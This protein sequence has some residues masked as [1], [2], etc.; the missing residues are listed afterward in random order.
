LLATSSRTLAIRPPPISRP[1]PPQ[2][3]KADQEEFE[4]LV[5]AAQTVGSS[6]AATTSEAELQH[7]DVRRTPKPDFEGDVNPVTGERGGPKKD[8]F[9]AGD[10][11]W[12]FSGRVTV[13]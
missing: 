5:K 13:S 12:Q 11:D 9:L 10:A 2:L 6:P 3:P 7:P 8:P 4:K 1:G